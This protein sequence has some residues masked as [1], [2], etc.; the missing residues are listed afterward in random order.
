MSCSSP[1]FSVKD[2]PTVINTN[3][4][5]VTDLH[6][7]LNWGQKP[8]KSSRKCFLRKKKAAFSWIEYI[9][10]IFIVHPLPLSSLPGS[11][12]QDHSHTRF[13]H[14]FF[15]HLR[16]SKNLCLLK[17]MQCIQAKGNVSLLL[18]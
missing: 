18:R 14:S 12:V 10:C 7:A 3:L 5:K 1:F 11:D 2:P 9:K 16:F 17:A 4:Q 13:M 15:Q 8:H 6:F